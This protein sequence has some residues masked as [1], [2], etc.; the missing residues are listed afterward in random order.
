M[1]LKKINIKN[2]KSLFDVEIKPG[3]VNVIIGANGCGKSAF[4]E[5][6]GV[7]SAA[8]SDKV[9]SNSLLKRGVRFGT[10]A[11]YK[12]SFD[13]LESLPST[14]NFKINWDING[15]DWSYSVDLDNPI[16]EPKPSWRYFSESLKKNDEQILK[17]GRSN[18]EYKGIEVAKDRSVISFVRGDKELKEVIDILNILTDYGIYTPNTSTLR[19]IQSDI[20][21]RDPIGLCGG[22]LPEAIDELMNLEN[23]M[24]GTL[25]LDELLELLDW[26]DAIHIGKPTKDILPSNIPTPQKTIRFTDRYMR[27][28][29]TVVRNQLTAYDASEGSLYVLFLLAL[30]MH[31]NASNIFA[32]DNFD[33]ALN[34]KLA[35]KTTKIFC[36]QI[37][38]HNKIAFI[39]T[40]NPL[41]LDGLNLK[42]DKIRLFAFDRNRFGHTEITRIELNEKVTL[43][44][45]SLSRLWV[46]GR[47]GG[48]PR[49]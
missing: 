3:N 37:I 42:N 6:I 31:T 32:V 9:D 8:V 44:E 14:I 18:R 40:H 46:M 47:L 23:E 45:D 13:N 30:A 48:V 34:P 25:E 17:L 27:K 26:V 36:E 1:N 10:P 20:Y 5:A 43:K 2:F 7:L 4:L 15:D 24:F 39:T 19:G 41:V 12:S 16:D 22:R 11:L 49:L 35:K 38:K 21:Q 33:Q 28:A 29:K